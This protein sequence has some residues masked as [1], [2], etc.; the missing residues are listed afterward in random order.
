MKSN[1][2]TVRSVWNCTVMLLECAFDINNQE[3]DF[4]Q[5]CNE[6]SR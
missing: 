3:E 6:I 1:D 2:Q 4:K 5:H